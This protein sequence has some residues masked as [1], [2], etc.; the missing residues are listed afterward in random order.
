MTEW[1]ATLGR[2]PHLALNSDDSPFLP[3]LSAIAPATRRRAFN[4]RTSTFTSLPLLGPARR[5]PTVANTKTPSRHTTTP[6]N[7]P[8]NNNKKIN[9]SKDRDG[10]RE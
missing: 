9:G 6:L 1:G 8:T 5:Q 7:P 2:L 10:S 3:P 4:C